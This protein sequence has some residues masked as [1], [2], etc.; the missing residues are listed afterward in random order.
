MSQIGAQPVLVEGPALKQYGTGALAQLDVVEVSTGVLDATW[1]SDAE[2]S[3]NKV[4]EYEEET[5]L[6][7]VDKV[8]LEELTLAD[9]FG[10][11]FY[12]REYLPIPAAGR[13]D[14]Q[15]AR[16]RRRFDLWE[17]YGVEQALATHLDTAA[18]DVGTVSDS[19]EGLAALLAASV[20]AFPW[21]PTV[22]T[23]RPAGVLIQRRGS[24][25]AS[26]V[27]LVVGSGYGTSDDADAFTGRMYLT[28]PV[29]IRRGPVVE[30][31]AVDAVNN[32][33]DT[34]IER[35]YFI[36]LDGPAYRVDVRFATEDAP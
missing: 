3:E 32:R 26:G 21:V 23:G 27:L 2:T 25:K 9:G 7:V 28:G 31:Q 17:S 13:Q 34:L 18:I 30:A 1:R 4:L 10:F 6:D 19:E 36:V 15:L 11:S 14:E 12:R 22:H 5:G 35:E 8:Q 16:T 33:I 29:Q 24:A 20:D